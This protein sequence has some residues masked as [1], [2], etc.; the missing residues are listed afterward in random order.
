[1]KI[2]AV[3]TATESCSV[4]IVNDGFPVAELTIVS[5]R[6]QSKHLMEMIRTVV[7]M[8]ALSV[9]DLD[10]FAVTQG[11]GSFT[12]LR[13]GIS[14]IKGLAAASGKPLVGIS[15]LEALA[16]QVSKCSN[17]LICPFLDARKK[18]VYFSLYRFE[19]GVLKRQIAEQVLPPN[20]AFDAIA[21][22]C[23]F[24]GNGV[25]LYQ[26]MISDKLGKAAYFASPHQNTIRAATIAY[27]SME[28]FKKNDTDDISRFIPHYIRKSDAELTKE[29]I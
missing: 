4:A 3:D 16:A 25:R 26:K 5:S 12:G 20:R 7:N 27:L 21:E 29:V 1:M 8:S 9:S 19:S 14:T 17:H 23:L 28:K 18:E 2:L 10:G 24:I 6:M 15:S 13:I 22:P 11:P